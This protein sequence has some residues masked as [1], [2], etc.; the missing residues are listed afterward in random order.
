MA[1]FIL[2]HSTGESSTSE[3]FFPWLRKE[4]E[5]RGHTVYSPDFP[6]PM[7]QTLGNWLKAFAPYAQYVTE[8]TIFIGRSIGPAFILRLLEKSPVKVKAA[9]FVAGFCSDIGLDEFMPLINTFIEKKFQWE[10]I[11][12]N[13]GKFFVYCSDNDR[14]VPI[15]NSRELAK[16]LHTRIKIVN[17][18][19]HFWMR[20]FPRLLKDIE[21]V[22]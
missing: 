6:S 4:L 10:K 18:V 2:V 13:C 22:I 9:F 17:G 7:D 8:N 11:R 16:N 19:D 5:K 1:T 20:E 12:Q 15:E 14:Y 21:S 3:P